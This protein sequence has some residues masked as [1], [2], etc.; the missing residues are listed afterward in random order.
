M[1]EVGLASWSASSGPARA[2]QGN[3][4]LPR[5]QLEHSLR[6]RRLCWMSFW[7]PQTSDGG[8]LHPPIGTRHRTQMSVE[9]RTLGRAG[10][11]A[12]SGID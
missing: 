1:A 4:R 6:Q 5:V 9:C 10:P 7:F 3:T 12:P 2:G 11:P 8:S